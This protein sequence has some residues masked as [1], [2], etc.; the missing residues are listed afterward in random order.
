[1]LYT[2]FVNEMKSEREQQGEDA[3]IK[4]IFKMKVQMLSVHLHRKTSL[5]CLSVCL[6]AGTLSI[7]LYIVLQFDFCLKAHIF[8]GFHLT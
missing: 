3:E 6:S 5:D 7:L 1:M 8:E 4:C 2:P